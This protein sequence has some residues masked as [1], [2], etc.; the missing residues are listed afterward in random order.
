MIYNMINNVPNQVYREGCCWN[1][2]AYQKHR[3]KNE[4]EEIES[5]RKKDA[6]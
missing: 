2:D 3:E 6:W 1:V 5:E 4:K